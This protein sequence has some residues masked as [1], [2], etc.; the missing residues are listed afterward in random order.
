VLRLLT[1]K[2]RIKILWKVSKEFQESC[3]I[4]KLE[5][6]DDTGGGVPAASDAYRNMKTV[7]RRITIRKITTMIGCA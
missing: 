6:E 1:R 4:E 5:L 3:I 7:P 2:R